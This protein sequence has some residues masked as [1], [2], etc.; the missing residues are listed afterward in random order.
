MTSSPATTRAEATDMAE[1]A[2]AY[3]RSHRALG[4]GYEITCVR[5]NDNRA[6]F[7][8]TLTGMCPQRGVPLEWEPGAAREWVR[9]QRRGRIV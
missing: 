4:V 1:R 9:K 6:E 5:A 8:F 7:G 3:W 2:V